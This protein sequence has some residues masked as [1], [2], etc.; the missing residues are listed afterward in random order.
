MNRAAALLAVNTALM[1]CQVHAQTVIDPINKFTWGENCGWM[2]WRDAGAQGARIHAT[3]LSGFIWCENTGWI[4]LGDGTPGSGPSYS[5]SSGVDSG[6]NLDL[7]SGHL[8]GFAWGENIGWINFTGA[9]S[10]ARIDAQA[11]RLR[12]YAWGENIGWINL[13][14]ATHFVGVSCYANCDQSTSTPILNVNDFVCFN[15]AYSAGC[16]SPCSP[17]P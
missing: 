6:V 10:P 9:P 3:F 2:N 1:A 12:G 5:N 16:A 7:V 17:H 14:D 15:N 11:G 13:D 4:N 8:S